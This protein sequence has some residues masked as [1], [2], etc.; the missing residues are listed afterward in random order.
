MRERLKAMGT[1]A[2][3]GLVPQVGG[4]VDHRSPGRISLASWAFMPTSGWEGNLW[5][6]LNRG[7][8]GVA[9]TPL[10]LHLSMPQRPHPQRSPCWV[11]AKMKNVPTETA[12]SRDGSV[13]YTFWFRVSVP[14]CS[15]H[16]PIQILLQ[17]RTFVAECEPC[18]WSVRVLLFPA[19][20]LPWGG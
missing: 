7:S 4:L 6:F 19:G 14:H 16:S 12:L 3:K 17:R 1:V 20:P 15:T 18:V 9:A 11:A 2:G 10:R 5:L 8:R 13:L